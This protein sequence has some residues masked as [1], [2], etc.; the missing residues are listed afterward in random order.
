LLRGF[1]MQPGSLDVF[2]A[3]RAWLAWTPWPSLLTL[4]VA[5][6]V[7]VLSSALFVC[8]SVVALRVQ[9]APA[10]EPAVVPD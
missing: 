8:L 10:P 7:L 3:I 2:S 6:L 5:A 4:M 9:A 1:W